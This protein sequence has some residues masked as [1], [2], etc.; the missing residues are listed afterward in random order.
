MMRPGVPRHVMYAA[1]ASVVFGGLATL[2]VWILWTTLRGPQSVL[3]E[4]PGPLGHWSALWL[5]ATAAFAVAAIPR[6]ITLGLRERRARIRIT[7]ALDEV[8]AELRARRHA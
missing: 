4:L 6:A 7:R 8:D 3:A 5:I 1:A 2:L